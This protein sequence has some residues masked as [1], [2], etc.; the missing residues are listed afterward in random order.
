ML[1][2]ELPQGSA[3]GDQ[4]LLGRG[5]RLDPD[6]RNELLVSVA[7]EAERLQR[8]IENL[9]AMVSG[10]VSTDWPIAFQYICGALSWAPPGPRKTE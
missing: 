2:G 5:A 6:T 10:A 1:P 4:L 8:M 7:G 3:R 9:V